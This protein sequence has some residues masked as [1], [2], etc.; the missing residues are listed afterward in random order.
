MAAQP[1]TKPGHALSRRGSRVTI[2]AA[3]RRLSG[4]PPGGAA[5]PASKEGPPTGL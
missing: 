5:C 3:R 2:G 4:A 1:G